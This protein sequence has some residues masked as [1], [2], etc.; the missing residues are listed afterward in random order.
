MGPVPRAAFRDSHLHVHVGDPTDLIQRA[1]PYDVILLQPS[2]RWTPRSAR[3]ATVDELRLVHAHLRPEGLVCLWVPS[4]ALTREGFLVLLATWAKVFPR[5]EVWAGQGG[6]VLLLADRDDE[7]HDFGHVLAAYENGHI[8]AACRASWIATPETLLSQFLLAD[9]SVRRLSREYEPATTRNGALGRAEVERR[10][11]EPTVDPVPGLAAIRDD[12]VAT[13]ENTP[14]KG[15][16]AAIARAVQ[17]RDLEWKG[18]D[19]EIAGKP[20]DAID[21][22]RSAIALNPNDGAV[23]RAF[24][25]LRSQ[26][27]IQFGTRQS[28]FAAHA[29]MRE[30]VETDTTYAEGF[31]NLGYLLA[32]GEDFDYAI[33]C[34]GQAITLAP[35][36]DLFQLQMGRIWKQRGYFDKALPYY[37]AAMDLNPKNVEAAIGYVDTKLSMEGDSADLKWGLAFLEKYLAV[38]PHHVDLQY[39][40]GKL[41]SVLARRARGESVRPPPAATPGKPASTAPGGPAPSAS[42]PAAAAS[43]DSASAGP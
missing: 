13:L 7:P 37:Q 15:F 43:T 22:Y 9:R 40:I 17:A 41:K 12:V 21:A 10:R 5:V 2:G 1:A 31:A 35:D 29:Y 33:A 32:Q 30:A 24:A 36:D 27:G 11:E 20:G 28:F 18:L 38:D 14:A 23:R 4:S 19:L 34:T 39:R 16:A 42:T 26:Q 25:T 8:A 3:L 6:D